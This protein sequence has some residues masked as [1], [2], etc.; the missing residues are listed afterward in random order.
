MLPLQVT[1]NQFN[2]FIVRQHGCPI[3]MQFSGFPEFDIVTLGS[4][5]P[6]GGYLLPDVA[7]MELSN[8]E[9]SDQIKLSFSLLK[10][11]QN[12]SNVSTIK[13]ENQLFII[14]AVLQRSV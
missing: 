14:L 13:I 7:S 10:P 5:A 4:P 9:P 1:S 6:H 8:E 11:I 3:M 2:I 12:E